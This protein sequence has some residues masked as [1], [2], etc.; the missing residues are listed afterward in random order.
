MRFAIH[1]RAA[2]QTWPQLRAVWQEAHQIELAE[3]T[4]NWDY[5]YPFTGDMAGSA[6]DRLVP[7]A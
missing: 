6:I 2:R 3:S 5:L 1:L 7:R 4:W